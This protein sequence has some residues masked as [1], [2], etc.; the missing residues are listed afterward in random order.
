[1]QVKRVNECLLCMKRDYSVESSLRRAITAMQVKTI[2]TIAVVTTLVLIKLN[3]FRKVNA[4]I[5]IIITYISCGR[6]GRV[7]VI[8]N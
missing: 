5:T 1:M 8:I 6:G 7:Q 3:S 4:S 2:P